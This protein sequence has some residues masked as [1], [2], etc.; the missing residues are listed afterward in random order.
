L[1][2]NLRTI[3]TSANKQSLKCSIKV[4]NK[5]IASDAQFVKCVLLHPYSRTI[6]RAQTKTSYYRLFNKLL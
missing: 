6:V 2:K 1:L 4:A 5:T 3:P